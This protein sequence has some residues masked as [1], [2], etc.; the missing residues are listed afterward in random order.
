M[1]RYLWVAAFLYVTQIPPSLALTYTPVAYYLGSQPSI[2]GLSS[3]AGGV[4]TLNA[5]APVLTLDY[6]SE[7]GGWPFVEVS[8]DPEVPVQVEFK[9]S[10][11]FDGLNNAWG[12]GP[13]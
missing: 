2:N 3:Y 7:V 6:G 12:D 9:Y 11:P 5:S 1:A 10:E 4:I 13:W 8:V